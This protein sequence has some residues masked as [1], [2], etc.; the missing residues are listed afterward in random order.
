MKFLGILFLLAGCAGTG[1]Y[2]SIQVKN[3]IKLYQKLLF[4]IED[5]EICFRYQNLTLHE[6]FSSLAGRTEYQ[7]FEFLQKL[8][9]NFKEETIPE[10]AWQE[11]LKSCHFPDEAG[12]ILKSLGSEL[13]KSDLQGQTEI[14]K[15]C[16][17]Q[18]QKALQTAQANSTQKCRLYQSLGWLGGA[19]LAVILL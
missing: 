6:L 8:A 13:G 11:A 18:M 16:Q 7:N 17:N 4:F 15:L 14:L 12:Q 9:E 3:Q 5:C 19:M 10:K 2:A 1:V